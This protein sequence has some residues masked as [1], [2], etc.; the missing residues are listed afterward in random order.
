[1]GIV[2]GIKNIIKSIICLL[3]VGTMLISCDTNNTIDNKFDVSSTISNN[4]ESNTRYNIGLGKDSISVQV[5]HEPDTLDPAINSLLD[6]MS[7]LEHI[8]EG[9]LK[10]DK[11]GNL[12]CGIAESYKVS[13]DGLTWA[14]KLR[15][16]LKWSDGTSFDANDLVYTWK[17]VVAPTTGSSYAYDLLKQVVGYEEASKGDIDALSVVA[18]DDKTFVVNLESPCVY[19]D[20]ICAFSVLS[21]VKKEVVSTNGNWSESAKTY[22]SN[23]PYCVKMFSRDSI[24]LKKNPYYYDEKNVKLNE[25]IFN[26]Q[27]NEEKTY[28]MYESNE[29]QLIKDIPTYKMNDAKTSTDFH[30]DDMIG[31]FYL[32]INTKKAP[33]DNVNVRKALSLAIDRDYISNI[34]MQG[35]SKVAKNFVG[36]GLTDVDGSSFEKKTEEMYKEP[37]FNNNQYEKNFEEASRLLLEAGFNDKNRFPDIHFVLNDEGYNRAISECVKLYWSRLGINV[38]LDFYTK[39]AYTKVRRSGKFDIARSGWMCDWD[40]P[41]NILSVFETFSGHNYG[42]YS[43][44]K[45]DQ[46]IK[47]ARET[48]VLEDHYY[49]LHLAERVLLEDYAIIPLYYYETYWLQKDNLKNVRYSSYGTFYFMN[50]Y[51]E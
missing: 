45:Y 37:F 3:L 35:T 49:K 19:F 40:D 28:N 12:V 38:K 24:T 29:L 11:N 39:S 4:N 8:F 27:D 6:G 18:R 25:I 16:N 32:T 22:I 9:L 14:F 1:M 43:S 2:V 51:I 10:Y 50:A 44:S 21:P 42:K 46:L 7:I 15:D 47:E 17:R 30:I 26:F 36:P 13:S 31:T 20:K 5:G 48:N 23:G 34:V 41:S 33:F